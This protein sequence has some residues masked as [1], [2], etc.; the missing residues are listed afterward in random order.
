MSFSDGRYEREKAKKLLVKEIDPSEVLK[1]A[2]VQQ[3][4]TL[5]TF[6]SIVASN[7]RLRWQR[8]TLAG[9]TDVIVPSAAGRIACR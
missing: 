5:V 9:L 7:R 6:R 1:S 2:K 4:A 3:L 8:T